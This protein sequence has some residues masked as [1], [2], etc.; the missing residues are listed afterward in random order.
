MESDSL[1]STVTLLLKQ[2]NEEEPSDDEDIA[3]LEFKVLYK[4][5]YKKKEFV[6]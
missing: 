5:V 3:W 2:L 6:Y 4:C 1:E